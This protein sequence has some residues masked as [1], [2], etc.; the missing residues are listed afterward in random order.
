MSCNVGTHPCCCIEVNH[1]DG[2]QG[3][4]FDP[5]TPIEETVQLRATDLSNSGH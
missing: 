3:H 4:R 2:P 5:D 1:I